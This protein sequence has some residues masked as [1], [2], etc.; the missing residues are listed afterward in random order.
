MSTSDISLLEETLENSL[1]QRQVVELSSMCASL[2]T[3]LLVTI[4]IA[5]Q[6][7]RQLQ[8]LE[9]STWAES[10]LRA[11]LSKETNLANIG[12]HFMRY[13]I[14][15]LERLRC[16]N[17]VALDF[18]ALFVNNGDFE[19]LPLPLENVNSV[20]APHRLGR[21]ECSLA[22]GNVSV[23]F[24]WRILIDDEGEIRNDVTVSP[25]FPE[26]WLQVDCG[27]E[28]AKIG[29]AFDSLKKEN[30]IRQAIFAVAKLIFPDGTPPTTGATEKRSQKRS[31]AA[32]GK[33][34]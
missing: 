23:S 30:G 14:L 5:S 27:A 15:C 1:V 33:D 28:L 12:R 34:S 16:W 29:E 32:E 3:R 20:C 17:D 6:I 25:K 4:N 26:W 7:I 24:T 18:D 10:E 22:R 9:L 2:K 21:Q 11:N 13:S 8:V 31:S 19:I